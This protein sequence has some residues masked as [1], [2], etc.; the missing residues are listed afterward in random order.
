MSPELIAILAV[1]VGLAGLVVTSQRNLRNDLR[2]E[3]GQARERLAKLK[4]LL[5]GLRAAVTGR[6]AAGDAA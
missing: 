2:E 1:G 6:R 3:M 4:G 5:E